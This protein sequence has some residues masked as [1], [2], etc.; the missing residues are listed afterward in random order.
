[1]KKN[2]I[3]VAVSLGLAQLLLP[4]L[5]L[6][7]QDTTKT[8]NTV[9]VTASRSPKKLADIGRV[10]TVI[11]TAEISRS[12]GKTL[13]EVLNSV[14]GITFSGAENM[15]GQS[16]DVY[17]RGAATGN[18]LILIDGFP[19]NDASTIA[20]N[21]NLNAFPV[22]QIDHIEILKGSGSTLYGSDAVAGVINIITKHGTAQGL[23][24][25]VQVSGG[26][27]NTFREAAG[28]NG[29]I[30]NTDIALNLSSID[31]RGFSVA[32]DKLAVGNFDNDGFHQRA[33]SLNI[34]QYVSQKFSLNGNFQ[35]SRINGDN[36]ADA[37]MDDPNSTY[38]Q[39]SLFGGIGGKYLLSK[40]AIVANISQNNV[41]NKYLNLPDNI[42]P[43]YSLTDNIGKITNAEAIFTYTFNRYLDLTSGGDYKYSNTTQLSDYAT[44]GYAPGP[45]TL[46]PDVANTKISSVYSSLFF[47]DGTF[48]MELGGRYNNHNRYGSNF[49]Y[50]I[51]PSVLVT[52]RLKLFATV[53]S[54][55]KAP[56]LYQLY[57]Q[58]GNLAL[59]PERTAASYEA[60]FDIG[61]VK[62][63][64]SFNTVFYERQIRDVIAFY[65]D[66]KTF[67]SYYINA[68]KQDDKGFE[69]ELTL[70]TNAITGSVWVAYVT[71]KQTISSG[72]EANNLFRRPKNTFGANIN[73]Q[74]NKAFSI[75]L[76]YK[77]T[78]DRIDNDFSTYPSKIVT[79]QHYSLLDAHLQ[80]VATRK[81]TLFTDL[82]NI[83]DQKYMD[84]L[85]YNT[86]RF[87]F[88]AGARYLFN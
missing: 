18:T 30:N 39:L 83:L 65:T 22:D 31:S 32:N 62:N 86:R 75:G 60:G 15:I 49:T 57:S 2:Y 59:K 1:M 16:Q 56:S 82:K 68:N 10:V 55:Y 24:A 45:S 61:I 76:N 7:A 27:Y 9:V 23:K 79:L 25:N 46:S 50:T 74:V 28:L 41:W 8:L 26:S 85:G 53:A 6:R 19:A 12:Q 40:G 14:P 48:H 38:R 29:K 52:N 37:F 3:K 67:K 58:Y 5:K 20:G 43:T 36:D 13:P 63:V 72:D 33:G 21:F 11:T 47:K 84:W 81:L 35:L 73:Y 66:P 87:N 71:G 34:T 88:V 42:S 4:G 17:V 80:L 70:H 51:N 64:L 69:S 77:Y 54:A 78:G 44:T